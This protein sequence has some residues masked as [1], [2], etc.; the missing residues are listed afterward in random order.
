MILFPLYSGSNPAF[1]QNTL[2]GALA[3]QTKNG[4]SYTENEVEV[5]ALA[6]LASSNIPYNQAVITAIGAIIIIANRYQ[7][8]GWRDYSESELNQLLGYY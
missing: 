1:G 6:A 7:E 5:R 3:L 4:F 2:G 8:D